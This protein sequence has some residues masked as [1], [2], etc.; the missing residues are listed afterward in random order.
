MTDTA[1]KKAY[2]NPSYIKHNGFGGDFMS[3]GSI[4]SE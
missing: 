2:T 4:W 3:H 1:I